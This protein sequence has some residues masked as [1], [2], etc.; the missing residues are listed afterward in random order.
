[1]NKWEIEVQKSL[2]DSEEEALKELERQYRRALKEVSVKIRQFQTDISMIDE[3]LSQA[4][5]DDTTKALLQSQKQSKIYQQQYQKALQ[6]QI[7]SIL[8]KMHS[9]NYTTVDKYL[10]DCYESGYAGTMYNLAQQGMP[11]IAPIDQA[12]EVK[13]ILTDSKVKGSLYEAIGVDV[14]KLKKTISQE[15]S[16]GIATGM[17]YATIARNIS[18]ASNAPLSKTKTIARTEGHRIQETST[19]DA[20]MAAKQ[21]GIDHIK[22]WDA[23]LDGKTRDSHR[24]VD[25]E[26]R[27][28]EE[29]FSNGLMFP[30]DSNGSAAEVVNCRCTLLVRARA[31]MDESELEELKKRAA[32]FGL[33]KTANFQ[34]FEEKYLKAAKTLEKSGKSDIIDTKNLVIPKIKLTGYALD[35]QKAPDKAKAFKLALGY[36]QN[37]AD[38]LLQNIIDNI[39]ENKFVEKGDAGYGTL[40]QFVVRLTGANGKKANVL[41]A[42][43][44]DGKKKR[45]ISVY[46]TEKEVTE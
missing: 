16:R 29:K 32:Y 19:F 36:D 4:G 11:I 25:G 46:V 12:A 9:D 21:R 10:H 8:D 33:D 41:T 39:D 15:I 13:A 17:G 31:A 38:E 7:G 44:A 27:E 42:W 6:Q 30:G 5:L 24:Q 14:S 45:L 37:N 3:A 2:L 26:I 23:S 35:P 43:I 18:L 34:E 28:L 40:Y 22:Q 1:M 20:A